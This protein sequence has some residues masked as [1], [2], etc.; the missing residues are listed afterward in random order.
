MCVCGAGVYTTQQNKKNYVRKIK[1]GQEYFFHQ[2]KK[3]SFEQIK[4][5]QNLLKE[6][7]SRAT[8]RITFFR[9]DFN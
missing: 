1:K 5:V 6:K 8:K 7:M 3:K 2:T 9:N 4:N